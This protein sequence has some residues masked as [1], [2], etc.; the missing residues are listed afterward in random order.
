[1]TAIVSK[2]ENNSDIAGPRNKKIKASGS[3]CKLSS[4][5]FKAEGGKYRRYCAL[6]SND[7]R[8]FLLYYVFF[9]FL[10]PAP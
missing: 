10:L 2:E 5:S 6:S 8:K 4:K 3:I 1:M 9:C 7:D